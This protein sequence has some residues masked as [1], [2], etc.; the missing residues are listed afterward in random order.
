MLSESRLLLRLQVGDVAV[1]ACPRSCL[2]QRAD[3]HV[4]AP[5]VAV[6]CKDS[7][8]QA[9]DRLAV[10][11]DSHHA[12]A[13][14]DRPIQ[15]FLRVAGPDLSP[16]RP[17]GVVNAWMSIAASWSTSAAERNV[18]AASHRPARAVPAPTCSLLRFFEVWCGEHIVQP[19]LHLATELAHTGRID[20]VIRRSP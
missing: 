19:I 11:E 5:F 10:G 6:L 2:L 7:T 17:R 12:T 3:A 14:E 16:H 1:V 18:V 9:D 8:D 4:A 15:V 13:P 20:V